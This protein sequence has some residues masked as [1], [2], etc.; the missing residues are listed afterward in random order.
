[1]AR[2]TLTVTVRR[3]DGALV[4]NAVVA[5]RAIHPITK[6]PRYDGASDGSIVGGVRLVTNAGG[7]AIFSLWP[8]ADLRLGSWYRAILSLPEGGVETADFSMPDANT[9]LAAAVAATT[10]AEICRPTPGSGGGASTFLDL[11]DTPTSYAGLG[12]RY[13]RVRSSETGLDAQA[14][15]NVARTGA[16]ADL[17]GRPLAI[18]RFAAQDADTADD[19]QG[20]EIGLFTADG[21]Q[22]QASDITAARIID[23]PS[24][25]AVFGQDAADGSTILTAYDVSR[26]NQRILY[27]QGG[28]CPGCAHAPWHDE[29]GLVRGGSRRREDGRDAPLEHHAPE[30]QRHGAER[31]GRVERRRRAYARGR[32]P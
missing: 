9:S 5:V 25:A 22:I 1:M 20:G 23:L 27:N 7:Q 18:A 10:G 17:T 3:P 24:R 2:R 12:G 21:T 14:L 8:Q 4:P 29:H 11:T 16:Y 19:V 31:E 32:G 28:E 6:A 13:L 30:G 15:A 26:F